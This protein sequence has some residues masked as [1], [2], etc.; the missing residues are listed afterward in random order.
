[1]KK[2]K[3]LIR[4]REE[5]RSF[6]MER[7]AKAQASETLRRSEFIEAMRLIGGVKPRG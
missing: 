6:K 3:A 2:D 5:Q 7:K 4:S 1:M